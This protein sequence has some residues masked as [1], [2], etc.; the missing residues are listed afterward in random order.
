MPKYDLAVVGAGLGGL[1]AAALACRMNK[2]TIVLEPGDS[3]GGA[4][5]LYH[6][7]G[8][9]FYLGPSLS[10]GFERGGALQHLNETL[11][12]A[13]NASLRSPCYQVVLPDRRITVYAEQSETLDELRRE[14][15]GEIDAIARFYQDIR[16]HALQNSKSAV[17]AFLRFPI[18][19]DSW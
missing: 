11:G 15:P 6:R 9:S 10:F 3:V 5:R 14:F 1:A 17:S 4:L 13:Q 16:K 2:K 8:F 18:S 7:N 12:I 19:R